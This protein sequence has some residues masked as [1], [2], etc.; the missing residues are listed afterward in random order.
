MKEDVQ[1]VMF[2]HPPRRFGRC[3]CVPFICG[4]RGIHAERRAPGIPVCLQC[5]E[6]FFA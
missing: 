2:A 5:P 1:M 4:A 6:T 3:A